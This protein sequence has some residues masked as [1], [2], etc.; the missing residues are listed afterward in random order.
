MA[1]TTTR[2]ERR[3]TGSILKVVRVAAFVAAGALL[4]GC[5]ANVPGSASAPAAVPA[6]APAKASDVAPGGQP[7]SG[8]SRGS[9]G[10]GRGSTVLAAAG[11]VPLRTAVKPKPIDVVQVSRPEDLDGNGVIG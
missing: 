5:G 1:R 11:S 7:D 3:K 2:D 9:Q 10:S 6:A 8:R 4:S